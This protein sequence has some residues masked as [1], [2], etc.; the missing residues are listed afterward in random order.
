MA[1]LAILLLGETVGWRRG[2][3]IAVG[4]LGVLIVLRPGAGA[5]H[6]ASLVALAGAFS[7]GLVGVAVKRLA[8]TESMALI[9]LSFAVGTILVFALPAWLVWVWPSPADLGRIIVLSLLGVTSQL[10]FVRAC[11]LGELAVIAPFDYSRLLFATLLGL[12]LFG[13]V[14]AWSTLLGAAVIV[15]AMLFI[16]YREA[17][18][19]RLGAG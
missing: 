7:S 17:R 14:P 4:F 6:P 8:R 9:L 1:L 5:F 16:L 15:G 18:L 12:W 19:R 13:E 11:A 10:C 3:A 2:L